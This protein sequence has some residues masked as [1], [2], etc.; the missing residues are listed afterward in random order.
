LDDDH[1]L[2]PA[3]ARPQQ[4]V[5]AADLALYPVHER[6]VGDGIEES[7]V[8]PSI[9]IVQLEKEHNRTELVDGTVVCPE[10]NDEVV[11][12]TARAR[13][14]E[15][16]CGIL[17]SRLRRDGRGVVGARLVQME[18]AQFALLFEYVTNGER[19]ADVGLH[20]GSRA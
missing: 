9:S 7:V 1:L 15:N 16:N 11:H 19:G 18:A 17:P 2:R 6:E 20:G 8:R 13:R 10:R 12:A 14:S 5:D 4:I 3:D